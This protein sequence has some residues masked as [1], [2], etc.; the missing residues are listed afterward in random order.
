MAQRVNLT[1]R[2]ALEDIRAGVKAA[3]DGKD[4]TAA[5]YSPTGSATERVRLQAWLL[6]WLRERKPR[7]G[8]PSA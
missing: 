1:R 7:G 5:P 3:R 8:P 2:Q 4:S 6:G